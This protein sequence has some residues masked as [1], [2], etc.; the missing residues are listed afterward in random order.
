M[1]GIQD[2]IGFWTI[3]G[4]IIGSAIN[5]VFWS[6]QTRRQEK[7]QVQILRQ[8]K[9]DQL[10]DFCSI[11]NERIKIIYGETITGNAKNY[12]S[13]AQNF[14]ANVPFYKIRMVVQM[15]FPKCINI[16]DELQ[17][18]VSELIEIMHKTMRNESVTFG[19]LDQKNNNVFDKIND[20]QNSI[21]DKYSKD[22]S[23]K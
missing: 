3:M 23:V 10:C 16:F 19:E 14:W 20:F 12:F 15:F 4:V 7:R 11:L 5:H 17:I 1:P 21:I 18:S 9:I 22:L 6:I 13:S 2:N 8:E